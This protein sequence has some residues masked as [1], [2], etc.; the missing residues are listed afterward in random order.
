MDEL[1]VACTDLWLEKL[2]KH[3]W[4]SS[5]TRLPMS[6][7]CPILMRTEVT[8]LCKGHVIPKSAKGSKWV[9]QRKDVDN[10]FGTFAEAGFIHGVRLRAKPLDEAI[11]YI[12]QNHLAHATNFSLKNSKLQTARARPITTKE[13]VR[14]LVENLQEQEA[15]FEGKC[16]IEVHLDITYETLLTCLHSVHLGLFRSMGYRYA[17]SS[18][19]RFVAKLLRD[20]FTEFSGSTN[21]K[22]R[23]VSTKREKLE[24][25]CRIYE[26]MVRPLD[27]IEPLHQSLLQDTFTEFIVCW[28]GNRPFA[29]IHLL[30]ADSEWNAVMNYQLLDDR[31]LAMITAE[32]AITFKTTIGRFDGKAVY[33]DPLRRDSST[34]VWPCGQSEGSTAAVTIESAVNSFGGRI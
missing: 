13:G 11:D 33:V 30:P 7:Y 3:V 18:Q 8:E 29:T 1:G 2:T 32:K 10:F 27:D 5:T 19:G 14:F 34:M 16:S 20:V 12:L 28:C 24:V 21:R 31:A 26:N 23:K 25:M 6:F 15:R 4:D 9:V 22:K 17:L